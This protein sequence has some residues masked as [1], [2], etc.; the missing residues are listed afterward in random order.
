MNGLSHMNVFMAGATTRG[1]SKSHA[2]T[3]MQNRLVMC[4]YPAFFETVRTGQE[5][6]HAGEE[7]VTEALRQ[8]GEGVCRQRCN[9]QAVCPSSQLNVHDGIANLLPVPPLLFVT[10]GLSSICTSSTP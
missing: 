10:C 9:D 8:L 4:C 5:A 2:L 1:L 7:V 6:H 3:W